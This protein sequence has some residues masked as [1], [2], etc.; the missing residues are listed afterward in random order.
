MENEW[1]YKEE[2]RGR[3][4]ERKGKSQGKELENDKRRNKEIKK[5]KE[6][7]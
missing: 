6:K 4:K 2:K 1:M 5:G 3:E 7:R